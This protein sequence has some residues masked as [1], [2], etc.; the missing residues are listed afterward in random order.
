MDKAVN[1]FIRYQPIHTGE[2]AR[3]ILPDALSFTPLYDGFNTNSLSREGIKVFN[4]LE[5]S[6]A[7][8]G[9]MWARYKEANPVT[10]RKLI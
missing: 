2:A 10:P 9:L 7:I 4:P 1:S 5:T 6:I 3:V 8:E